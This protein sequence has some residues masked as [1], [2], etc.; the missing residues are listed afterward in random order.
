MRVVSAI[1]L[2]L[3]SSIAFGSDWPQFRGPNADGIAPEKGINKDWKAK[4]PKEL[5]RVSLGD[6]GFAGP[7][8]AA[9][10]LFIIDKAGDE[11]LVRAIDLKTGKDVW[12]FKYPDPY[13]PGAADWG[14]GRSTPVY[15]S[16]KLY[17]QGASGMIHCLDAE[18]GT[19]IWSRDY[20]EFGG[21]WEGEWW[22]YTAAPIIDGNKVIYCPGGKG[23]SMVAF[24]KETGKEIWKGGGDDQAGY[25][26]PVIATLEGKKQYVALTGTSLMGVDPENGAVL[27]KTPWK[28]SYNVNATTPVVIDKDH[29]FVTTGYG[30]G[31]GLFKIAGGTATAVYTNKEIKSHFTTPILV[32]EQLYCISGQA[33][34]MG[35]DLVCLD[36]MAGKSIWRKPPFECGGLVIVDGAIIAINGKNGDITMAAVNP[37]EFVELGKIQVLHGRSWTAPIVADGKL[38]ARDMKE[39]VCLDLK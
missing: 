22:G 32:G 34:D 11:D 19:K 24:D 33:G 17:T 7:S 20:K 37:K 16:G 18:K 35:G 6:N 21:R 8:V 26:T 2:L 14:R 38:F 30:K 29:V 5:W 12:T 23:A 9:G 31:C 3:V 4:P 25:A 28:T 39:L 10:K 36:P 27:W 15:D 1:C 13:K